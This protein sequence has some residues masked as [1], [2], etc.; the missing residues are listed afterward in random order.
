MENPFPK[1]IIVQMVKIEVF[2]SEYCQYLTSPQWNLAGIFF[3]LFRWALSL[4]DQSP[5]TNQ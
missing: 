5:E 3:M 4:F 1:H 2:Y